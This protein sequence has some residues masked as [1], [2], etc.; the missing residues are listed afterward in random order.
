MAIVR[1]L[2]ATTL[3]ILTMNIF[4]KLVK[5]LFTSSN[6]TQDKVGEFE[7]VYIDGVLVEN[8]DK[9]YV[10]GVVVYKKIKD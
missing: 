2:P 5:R 7:N 3:Q 4:K 8:I 1:F 9:V 6:K 10:D